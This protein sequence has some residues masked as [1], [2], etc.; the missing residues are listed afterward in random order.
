[1]FADAA[2]PLYRDADSSLEGSGPPGGNESQSFT[3]GEDMSSQTSAAFA[4]TGIVLVAALSAAST[5]SGDVIVDQP[6]TS[7]LSAFISRVSPGG[8]PFTNRRVADNFTIAGSDRELTRITW[9]GG[10]ESSTPDPDLNN[11]SGFNIRIYASNGSGGAPGTQLAEWNLTKSESAPVAVPGQLVGLLQAPMYRF[12]ADIPAGT[13]LTSGNYWISIAASLFNVPDFDNEAWQWAGSTQTDTL[14]AQDRFDGQ[15]FLIR[16]LAVRNAA[17]R[18][19][20][21]IVPAPASLA[22][23][24]VAAWPRRRRAN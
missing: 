5:A 22:A 24:L 6:Q 8:F 1:M 9:W 4:R 13:T 20:A 19:E 15:G 23:L 18:I 16:T 17:F 3:E 10:D 7:G 2:A 12:S 14:I 11:L 21:D